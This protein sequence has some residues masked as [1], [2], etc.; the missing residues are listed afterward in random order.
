[1][2][3]IEL[4]DAVIN[5][6]KMKMFIFMYPSQKYSNRN[7]QSKPKMLS[8]HTKWNIMREAESEAQVTTSEDVVVHSYIHDDAFITPGIVDHSSFI[9]HSRSL[10]SI[11][12]FIHSVSQ[13]SI[14]YHIHS[15]REIIV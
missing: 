5:G 8:L 7:Q 3:R 6:I 12:L 14:T 2:N 4:I 9:R 15:Q 1:M 10:I 13:L 11:S